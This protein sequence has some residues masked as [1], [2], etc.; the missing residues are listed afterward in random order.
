MTARGFRRSPVASRRAVSKRSSI[1]RPLALVGV[2]TGG[3]FTDFLIVEGARVEA[4]KVA[5]T[6]DDPARAFLDGLREVRRRLGRGP[7]ILT[8]GFTVATNALLT[9]SGA[10]TSLVTTAGYEDLLAIGRQARPALYALAPRAVEPRMGG[11]RPR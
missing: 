3:T 11:P 2:D 6:P 1:R 9:R 8:H 5:S 7:D 10:R 4:F